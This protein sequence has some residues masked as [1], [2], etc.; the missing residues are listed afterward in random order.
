ME[1]VPPALITSVIA[2]LPSKI[3]CN[4]HFAIKNKILA[5][6]LLPLYAIICE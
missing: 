1:K 4:I 5:E 2:T 6:R 3:K